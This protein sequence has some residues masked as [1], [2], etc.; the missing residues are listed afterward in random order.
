[1]GIVSAAAK[2]AGKKAAKKTAKAAVK[3]TAAK[4]AAKAAPKIAK[5]PPL[6]AVGM[7]FDMGAG[8]S[9]GSSAPARSSF[10]PGVAGSS[11]PTGGTVMPPK[12]AAARVGKGTAAGM[13]PVA[14]YSPNRYTPLSMAPKTTRKV[15]AAVGSVAVTGGMVVTADQKQRQLSKA[16]KYRK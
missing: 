9:A 6:N 10:R 2:A 4:K 11:K 7:R 14:P 15:G 3:K 8:A 16:T 13:V 5:A 12:A 1:M